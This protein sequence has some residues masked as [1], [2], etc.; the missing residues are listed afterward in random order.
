MYHVA[1]A[2]GVP[3]V[4]ATYPPVCVNSSVRLMDADTMPLSRGTKQKYHG[5]LEIKTCLYFYNSFYH[6]GSDKFRSIDGRWGN[7][8]LTGSHESSLPAC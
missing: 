4:I 3:I 1:V 8:L 6:Q 2:L 7:S 5:S